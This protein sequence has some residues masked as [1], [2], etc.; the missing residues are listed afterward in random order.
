MS[1]EAKWM[2][3]AMKADALGLT[4]KMQVLII[5]LEAFL[6][7]GVAF[8]FFHEE[9]YK[10]VFLILVAYL[11][12]AILMGRLKLRLAVKLACAIKRSRT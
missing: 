6:W 11:P 2:G 4:L 9:P 10:A 3:V 1:S 8:W 7:F 12:F 5:A